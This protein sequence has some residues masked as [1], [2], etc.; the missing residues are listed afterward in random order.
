MSVMEGAVASA[1][2]WP[3]GFTCMRLGVLSKSAHMFCVDYVC[4]LC[5]STV[6]Y[7]HAC[8]ISCRCVRDYQLEKGGGRVCRT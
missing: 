4:V 6:H 2:D 3:L 7:M 8:I 1:K 5:M